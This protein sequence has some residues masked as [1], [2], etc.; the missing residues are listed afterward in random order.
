MEEEIKR[1]REIGWTWKAIGVCFGI[2]AS[3][4]YQIGTDYFEKKEEEKEGYEE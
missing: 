2:S 3:R 1:L 4:A